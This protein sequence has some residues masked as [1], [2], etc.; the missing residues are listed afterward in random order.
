MKSIKLTVLIALIYCGHF[1]SAQNREL[2]MSETLQR[3]ELAMAE[4][5]GKTQNGQYLY[6]AKGE[7]KPYTGILYGKY[8]NGQWLSRQEYVDGI[9][10]GSWIN[11]YDNGNLKEV[12]LYNQNRVEGAIKKYYSNGQLESEGTYREWRIRV[13]VWNYYNEK[14]VLVETVDHGDK[15]DYRDVKAMYTSDEISKRYYDYLLKN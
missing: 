6:Y 2:S 11:Y 7:K 12:G 3:R 8:P 10:Q 13:G 5:T 14:G 1:A 15:G 9:G 4:T